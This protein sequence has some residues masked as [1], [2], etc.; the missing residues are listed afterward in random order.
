MGVSDAIIWMFLSTRKASSRRFYHRSWRSY[1]AWFETRK[2][3]P[4]NYVVGHTLAFP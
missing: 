2:F 3:H 1:V 4:R